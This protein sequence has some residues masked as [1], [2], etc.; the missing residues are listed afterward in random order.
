MVTDE[1][2]RKAFKLADG[3]CLNCGRPHI[4][5]SGKYELHHAYFKS[6]YRGTDRDEAWNLMVLCVDFE[7]G[8]D[9]HKTGP[10][11]AHQCAETNA[12]LKAIA[13]AR[14]PVELRTGG[15][16]PD[17]KKKRKAAQSAYKKKVE[18][19]KERNGGLSPS[20]VAYR[21]KKEWMKKR[22]ANSEQL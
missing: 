11:A 22:L 4:F 13:D 19:F 12:K 1:E 18:R 17:L 3:K 16:H 14:K 9:C 15:V 20:Q 21:R 5:G 6:Q 2:A 10:T 8:I 7:A